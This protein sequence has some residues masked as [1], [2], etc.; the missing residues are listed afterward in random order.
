MH[1]LGL[2]YAFSMV[3]RVLYC[4]YIHVMYVLHIFDNNT[5]MKLSRKFSLT[6]NLS[7][8]ENIGVIVWRANTARKF[9]SNVI[10]FSN[11][12]TICGSPKPQSIPSGTQAKP[13]TR[14][15]KIKQI[16]TSEPLYMQS[17]SFHNYLQSRR[18]RAA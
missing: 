12:L 14:S 11:K 1:T 9:L 18:I 3:W 10:D 6:L 16:F 17:R 8:L 7:L 15:P 4:P 5:L 13:K 2:S